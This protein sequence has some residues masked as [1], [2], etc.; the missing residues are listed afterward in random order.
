[1]RGTFP[2]EAQLCPWGLVAGWQPPP[3]DLV[4]F[5]SQSCWAEVGGCSTELP[6][7]PVEGEDTL[8]PLLCLMPS[9]QPG[10]RRRASPGS[11]PSHWL[12]D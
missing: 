9:G 6:L 8:G 4:P 2:P 10:E 12:W 3:S 11:S 7:P 5:T 1:M